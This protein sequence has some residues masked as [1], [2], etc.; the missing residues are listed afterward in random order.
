MDSTDD[1]NSY[2]NP[3][4]PTNVPVSRPWVVH[5]HT[6]DKIL[7]NTEL[8]PALFVDSTAADDHT[9]ASSS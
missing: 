5:F 6:F 2:G 1:L 4:I 8:E 7:T 9:N 3:L